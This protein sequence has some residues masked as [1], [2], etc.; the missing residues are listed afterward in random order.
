MKKYTRIIVL[1]ALFALH[2]FVQAVVSPTNDESAATAACA[3][4][5]GAAEN[6][7]QLSKYA[8]KVSLLPESSQDCLNQLQKISL[9]Q[10]TERIKRVYEARAKYFANLAKAATREAKR[11]LKEELLAQLSALDDYYLSLVTN[12]ENNE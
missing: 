6:D 7:A 9:A 4:T 10:R 5:C 1:G 11:A 2:G 8:Q 3:V 12:G